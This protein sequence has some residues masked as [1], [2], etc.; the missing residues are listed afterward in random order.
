MYYRQKACGRFFL[1]ADTLE[2]RKKLV[3]SKERSKRTIHKTSE[4]S[5]G[6][7]DSMW[8]NCTPLN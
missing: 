7:N 4:K 6:M 8:S 5:E 1:Q 3:A 2:G